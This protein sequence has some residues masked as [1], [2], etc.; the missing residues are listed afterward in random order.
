MPKCLNDSTKSYIGSEPS[1]KG[2]GYSSSVEPVG[3]T[4]KGKDGNTWIVIETKKSKKWNK[5]KSE[6]ISREINFDKLPEEF[7]TYAYIPKSTKIKF[8]EETGLEDK[9]GGKN[10]FFIKG[11]TWPKDDEDIPM[12]FFCQFKDPRESNNYLYR[13]FLPIDNDEFLLEN[14]HIDKIE[15]NEENLKN[16]IIIK[17]DD[18]EN[19]FEP[20]KITGWK[21]IKELKSLDYILSK[22]NVV[23]SEKY[24]EEYNE[25]NY[26]PKAEI[27][28]GGT[29]VYCQYVKNIDGKS[30]LLQMTE[31]E[32]LD[33]QW[34]DAGIGHISDKLELYWDSC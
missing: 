16:Q 3:K 2:L 13:V 32:E 23:E 7:Y 20:F 12:R 19:N 4:M 30:Q 34:G 31:C 5:T 21:K 11:E 25:N 8:E 1:P 6:N 14:N 18:E 17:S 22:F 9:F 10:P 33:H 24:H 27:K 26:S 15:L 28:V 29:P